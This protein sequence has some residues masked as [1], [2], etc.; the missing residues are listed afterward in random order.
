MLKF[1]SKDT[2]EQDSFRLNDEDVPMLTQSQ[3]CVL[4]VE[5]QDF[6]SLQQKILEAVPSLQKEQIISTTPKD[7]LAMSSLDDTLLVYGLAE[8][9]QERMSFA[10]SDLLSLRA[11]Y[12]TLAWIAFGHTFSAAHLSVLSRMG[13]VSSFSPTADNHELSMMIRGFF[14]HK[15]QGHPFGLC[16]LTQ[17]AHLLTLDVS[18]R[19]RCEDGKSGI[20]EMRQG[21]FSHACF[22]DLQGP[23]ALRS[24]MFISDS[25]ISVVSSSGD[26]TSLHGSFAD[27]LI[28]CTHT[29]EEPSLTQDAIVSPPVA[30]AT[31]IEVD[32]MADLNPVCREVVDDVSDALAFGVVD[33]S[34]GMLLAA[35]HNVHYFTQSYL[36]AVAAA[37]VDMFR[38]KNV[39]RVEQLLSKH[40]GSTIQN[41][42]QE[43][44][45]RTDS[46]FHFMKVIQARN[47]VVVLVT[48]T[49]TNQ[50]MGWSGLR[51]A[52]TDIEEAMS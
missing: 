18:F 36:D 33:L 43:V 19:I 50:G 10:L 32:D 25:F 44:F 48:R 47:V 29:E 20:I 22:E 12:R 9:I 26:E 38:G 21:E 46:T 6:L 51:M 35:H 23:E 42:L 11:K 15:P 24:L 41:T 1:A 7:I 2:A 13:A 5:S 52:C 17:M 40:R 34:S 49:T 39:R 31:P 27:V 3:I 16:E 28:D 4:Q 8:N 45:T 37:A 30:S 14:Q